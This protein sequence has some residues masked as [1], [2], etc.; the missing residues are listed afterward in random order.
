MNIYNIFYIYINFMQELFP[1]KIQ[2]FKFLS[3]SD[4]PLLTS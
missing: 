4:K 3:A 2:L 1:N